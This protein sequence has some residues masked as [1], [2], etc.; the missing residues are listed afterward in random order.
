MTLIGHDDQIAAFKAAFSSAPPTNGT[1]TLDL[2][3]SCDKIAWRWQGTSPEGLPVRGLTFMNVTSEFKIAD[4]YI[5][6]FR[7]ALLNCSSAQTR[8]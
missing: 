2:F 5:E 7:P 4:T 1:K 6:Y 8:G 3:H